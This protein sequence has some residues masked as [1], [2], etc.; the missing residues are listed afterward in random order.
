MDPSDC[1]VF[2][3]LTGGNLVGHSKQ[4]RLIQN[5]EDTGASRKI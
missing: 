2:S 3:T 5:K 1:L 4:G